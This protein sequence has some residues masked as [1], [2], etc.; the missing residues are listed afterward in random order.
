MYAFLFD[1]LDHSTSSNLYPDKHIRLGGITMWAYIVGAIIWIVSIKCIIQGIR[2]HNASEVYE[3][4]G[5][6][7][8][9]TNLVLGIGR[10]QIAGVFSHLLWLEIIGFILF[11][12]SALL[13]TLPIVTL[14]RKGKTKKSA[15]PLLAPSDAT[16]MLDTGIFGVV[17]HPLYLGTALWSVALILVFQSILSVILG[18]VTISCFWMASTKED[19]F[20]I[21]KFGDGYR[22]YMKRVPMWN[23]FAGLRKRWGPS[24][25][26]TMKEE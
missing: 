9:F 5:L 17:R 22:G 25:A 7:V 21:K 4:S 13:V 19:E 12:P 16:I 8:Y 3:H 15:S 10:P 18:I 24:L 20:N 23:L 11:I 6:A 2:E 14:E 1:A 26:S